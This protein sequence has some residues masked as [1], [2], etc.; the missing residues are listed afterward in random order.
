MKGEDKGNAPCN[1]RKWLKRLVPTPQRLEV[2]VPWKLF[3]N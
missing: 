2:L 1:K 3:L